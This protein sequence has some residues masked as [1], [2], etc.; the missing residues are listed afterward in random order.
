M[1]C[2]EADGSEW[3]HPSFAEGAR[4]FRD[5]KTL[6]ENPYDFGDPAHAGW[7]QGWE[8]ELRKSNE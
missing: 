1:A 2:D 5:G 4:A 6:H 8:D 7:A 3:S